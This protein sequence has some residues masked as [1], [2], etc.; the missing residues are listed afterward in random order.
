MKYTIQEI[1]KIQKKLNL[2]N[3]LYIFEKSSISKFST[4]TP[5]KRPWQL[6][7]N[8]SYK[9]RKDNKNTLKTKK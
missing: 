8:M 1:Q 3:I 5:K 7:R 2:L 9:C 4:Q 6:L